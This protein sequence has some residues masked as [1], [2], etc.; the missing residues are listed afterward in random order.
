MLRSAN[1]GG[2]CG[3]GGWRGPAREPR[4][5]RDAG[6]GAASRVGAGQ[7]A[8]RVAQPSRPLD[9]AGGVV[10]DRDPAPDPRLRRRRR[11]RRLWRRSPGRSAPGGSQGRRVPDLDLRALPGMPQRRPARVPLLPHAERAPAGRRLCRVRRGP[12]REPRRDPRPGELRRGR[13]PAHGVP[14][15]VPR[16]LHARRPPPRDERARPGRERR[17]RDRLHPALPA[18]GGHGVRDLA[19]RGEA[20][21]CSRP[22]RRGRVSGRA[23]DGS[24]HRRRHRRHRRRRGDRH[25]RR[26]DLGPE[27]PRR[28]PRRHRRGA[29]IDRGAESCRRS[30]TASSSA[31]SRSPGAR[32]GP[33]ASF[34]GSSISA[35]QERCARSS[36]PRTAS[37]TRARPSARWR[38][39]SC[40]GR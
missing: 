6:A 9:A 37:T 10:G 34:A 13:V 23:R 19:G 26:A 39:A 22:R 38:A 20:S 28:A 40:A 29:G 31:T 32:W 36:V 33:A 17:R 30:S 16:A 24:R 21:V 7:S 1:A 5:R 18:R 3:G 4:H 14:D 8:R 12:R 11:G 15:R 27:P 25:R 35:R 2:V